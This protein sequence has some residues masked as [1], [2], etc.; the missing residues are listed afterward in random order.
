M[1]WLL[2]SIKEAWYSS[3]RWLDGAPGV[4]GRGVKKSPPPHCDLIPGPSSPQ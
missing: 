1:P 2:Y 4:V 3:Y